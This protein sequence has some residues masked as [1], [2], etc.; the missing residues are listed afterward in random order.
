MVYMAAKQDT[1]LERSSRLLQS[2]GPIRRTFPTVFIAGLVHGWGL[3][4]DAG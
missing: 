1:V 3:R 2:T 4:A